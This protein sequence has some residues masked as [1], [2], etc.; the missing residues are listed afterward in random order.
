VT[1]RISGLRLRFLLVVVGALVPAA[2]VSVLQGVERLRL[3]QENVRDT[4][5]RSAYAAAIGDRNVFFTAEQ[6]LRTL[7]AEPIV[8]SGETGC[9]TRLLRALEAPN[10]LLNFAR[11][12]AEGRLLCVAVTPVRQ[13]NPS[14]S[15]WWQKVLNGRDFTIVG[16][17][18]SQTV[19]QDVLIG[20]LPLRK[21]DGSFDGTLNVAIDISWLDHI[22]RRKELS[23]GAVVALFDRD[24]KI[25]ASNNDGVARFVFA[26]GAKA[27]APA[28]SDELLSATGPEGEA[29]SYAMAPVVRQDFFVGFAMP[30]GHLFRFTYVHVTVDLLLPV[31]MIALASLAIWRATDRWA[32]RWIGLLQRMAAA[33]RGGHYSIRPAALKSAPREMRALGDALA[34]MAQAVNERDRRLREALEQKG[35][36][37]KEIHHRVKNNLQIVMSLLSLQSTRLA[38]A[39]AREAVD[40]AR[41]RVNALALVHRTIYELDRE[42]VIDVQPLLTEVAAQ[43]QQGLG[44]DRRR[45]KLRVIV[46]SFE[47]DGDSAIPLTLFVIEA[48]TNAY[49]H[50][51]PPG[52]TGGT[53]TLSLERLEPKRLRLQVVDDGRGVDTSRDQES[54]GERLMSAFAQQLAGEFSLHRREGG[55]T[56]AELTFPAREA[57]AQETSRQTRRPERQAAA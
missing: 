23:R 52:S 39:G 31:L 43:L 14:A 32:T 28:G 22:K 33:Y 55:G 4:L 50:G 8:R 51:F 2:L 35:L 57:S 16:P 40:Q 1:P 34:N 25:V 47:T 18:F 29:W 44:G 13:A 7:A 20:A 41:M 24:G 12:S 27:S 5:S 19:G 49:K 36:M 48:L 15:S 21:P 38:D 6:L 11:V 10:F 54:T 37:I 45:V 17:V 26:R 46:P 56:V 53:I 9:R 42:G 30:S 3:D